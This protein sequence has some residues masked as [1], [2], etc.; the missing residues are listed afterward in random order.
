MQFPQGAT[1]VLVEQPTYTLMLRILENAKIPFLGIR[2]TQ[3]GID[4]EQ[5]EKLFSR[6]DIKFFYT[7]PRYQN[8][9]GFCYSN[10]QKLEII[11]LTEKYGVYIVE[12]DYLA[13]LEVDQKVETMHTLGNKD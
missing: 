4:L 3:H 6:G 12:Y 9:T 8:P 2:R 1:K 7:M 11:S 13:D 5:L 10:S